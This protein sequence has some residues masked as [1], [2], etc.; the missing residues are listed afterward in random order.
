[1]PRLE[2]IGIAVREA[3]ATAALYER[4]FGVAP[5]KVETVAREG[6]RTHFIDA[7]TAKLELLEA[8]GKDS[9][10]A[11]FLDRRGEGLHHLAFEVD[12]VEATM[13]RLREA[14]FHPLS[15]APRPGADGKR[16]FFL[17]PKETHGVLV[18]FCGSAALP[19]DTA[20]VP[21][22]DG[23][24]PAHTC[25]APDAPALVVLFRAS[26]A[27]LRL[28]DP[29]LRRFEPRFRVVALDLA[30]RSPADPSPAPLRAAL[31]HLGVARAHLFAHAEDVPA[32]LRFA[33]D[34]PERAAR[35][36][37]HA[38]DASALSDDDLRRISAPALLAAADTGAPLDAVL[39]LRRL[40]PRTALAVLPDDALDAFAPV[41]VRWFM[42]A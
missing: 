13:A 32:V 25:G 28:L 15:D 41:L 14:G 12:D 40:L 27:S 19:L 9:P 16:I 35:L 3:K 11:K 37:L 39:R 5:Y 21:F 6:V 36:A 8:L 4:L 24:F 34:H 10:V 26:G 1:M 42:A 18:E 2:H 38:P 29:L 30:A 31:D 23:S 17:H 7:G 33:R 20:T 22:G